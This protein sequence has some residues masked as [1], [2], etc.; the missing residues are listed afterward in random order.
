VDLAG[1]LVQVLSLKIVSPRKKKGKRKFQSNKFWIV[2]QLIMAVQAVG[3]QIRF[4]IS[5]QRTFHFT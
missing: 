2:Q 5:A 1:L 4:D 3:Q